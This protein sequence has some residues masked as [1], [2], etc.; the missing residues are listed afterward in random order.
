M[1]DGPVLVAR[2]KQALAVMHRDDDRRADLRIDR[3]AARRA[4]HRPLDLF[5]IRAPQRPQNRWLEYQR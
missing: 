1:L 2:E 3:V 5:P 4:D